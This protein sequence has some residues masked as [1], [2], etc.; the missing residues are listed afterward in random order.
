[1]SYLCIAFE[2]KHFSQRSSGEMAEWSIA[3]VLKTVVL[4]GTGGSNPSLS[5]KKWVRK[6]SYPLFLCLYPSIDSPSRKLKTPSRFEVNV[7]TFLSIPLHLIASAEHFLHPACS[8]TKKVNVMNRY[9][10]KVKWEWVSIILLVIL[11]VA[12]LMHP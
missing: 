4:R 7:S 11:L 10:W 6:H 9:E 2:T 8:L 3:A 5:A 12:L 1:M